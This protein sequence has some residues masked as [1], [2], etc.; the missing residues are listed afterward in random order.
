[1]EPPARSI[2]QP[3][4]LQGDRVRLRPLAERD[5]RAWVDAF[6]EDPELGVMLGNEADPGLEDLRARLERSPVSLAEGRGADFVIADV[7]TDAFLGAVN[8]FALHWH[9]RRGEVGIWLTPAARG[10]GL[11]SAALELMLGWVFDSLG[12]ERVEM[13]TIPENQQLP[14]LAQRLGFTQEGVLRARNVERGRRVDIVFYGL[15]RG[16]SALPLAREA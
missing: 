11:A 15:L 9:S 3:D 4:S 6:L 2:C 12:L 7:D 1:M 5:F 16:E 14:R 8:L 13:T 10:R